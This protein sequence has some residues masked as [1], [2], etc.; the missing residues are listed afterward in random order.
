MYDKNSRQTTIRELVKAG[1]VHSQEELQDLLNERGFA[2]TQATLSRDM[3]AMGIVKMHDPEYGYSYRLP[4][5][6]GSGA[7]AAPDIISSEGMLSIEFSGSLAVIKT[8]PGFAN[9]VGAIL[10]ASHLAVLMGTIAGDDTVLLVFRD[11]FSREDVMESLAQVLP[12][13]SRLVK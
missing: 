12:G 3:K 7:S 2:A 1:M 10:D 5:G 9:V 6:N 13:I 11:S 8:R 4:Y